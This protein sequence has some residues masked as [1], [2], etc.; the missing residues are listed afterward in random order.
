MGEKKVLKAVVYFDKQPKDETLGMNTIEIVKVIDADGNLVAMRDDDDLAGFHYNPDDKD[1][2][3]QMREF[4]A[5]K[6]KELGIEVSQ[7]LTE[8]DNLDEEL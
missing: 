8:Y 1:G 5:K 3:K 7:V 6:L 4:V 2:G